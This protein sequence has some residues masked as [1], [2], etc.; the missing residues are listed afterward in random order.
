MQPDAASSSAADAPRLAPLRWRIAL[1]ASAAIAI[2]YLD[3]QTLPV[4]IKAIEHDIPISNEGLSLLTTA[5]LATYG[6]MYAGGGK[7]VD[8]LGTRRSFTWIMLFWSLACASHGFAGTVAM[9]AASRLLLGMGEGGGFPAATRAVTEWF[10]ATERASAMG[11]IN[12]GTALGAVVAPPLIAAVLGFANW[13]VIFLPHGRPGARMDVFLAPDVL[14]AGGASRA[15][16]NRA[17]ANGRGAPAGG[18]RRT[19]DALARPAPPSRDAR[20]GGREI[21]ERRARGISTSSGCR[22]ISTTPAIL[23]SRRRGHS[24]GCRMRPREWAA[25]AADGSR[26]DLVKSA[27]LARSLA[28]GG[29]GRQR[30]VDA[31]DHARHACA[32][33][34]GDRAVQPRLFRPAIVVHACDGAPGG[35]FSKGERRLGG[36]PGRLWRRDGR[37]RVRAMRRLVA[38]PSL[39]VLSGI[40]HR[41]LVPCPRFRRDLLCHPGHPA[42]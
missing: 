32:G 38:G 7:L 24:H 13:R 40:R 1:L 42:P 2:S 31:L 9:L 37:H 35:H 10:P 12:A 26:V 3:R 29:A 6:I 8:A 39:R 15:R 22:S 21:P 25:C 19:P 34:L 28:Q 18:S 20:A 33:G 30:G 14:P 16:A 17:Q 4:A 23:T 5:F 11:I 27:A 36:G 41:G